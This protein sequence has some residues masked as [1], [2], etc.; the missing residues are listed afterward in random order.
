M[1]SCSMAGAASHT[2]FVFPDT[3]PAAGADCRALQLRTAGR[4]AAAL[5]AK[6]SALRSRGRGPGCV[7]ACSNLLRPRV[8]CLMF[9]NNQRR[10]PAWPGCAGCH[11]A[12][13]G[14]NP[15][16]HVQHAPR[17]AAVP[18][19]HSQQ[20]G[21]WPPTSGAGGTGG[22]EHLQRLV[23]LL[24]LEQEWLA[25]RDRH[26]P[27]AASYMRQGGSA[28]AAEAAVA[29]QI[30]AHTRHPQRL[31]SIAA[32]TQAGSPGDAVPAARSGAHR[33]ASC[34]SRRSPSRAPGR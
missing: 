27:V 23:H 31:R 29:E 8:C 34:P 25:G 9:R 2:G 30:G 12:P 26:G 21:C 7:H 4:H 20:R 1:A 3:D 10:Q 32:Y 11:R 15:R 13:R 24:Q 16:G 22:S 33:C 6:P 14:C 17:C 19:R 18:L 5:A 28:R